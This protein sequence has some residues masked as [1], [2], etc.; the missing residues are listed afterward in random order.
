MVLAQRCG[1]TRVTASIAPR[2]GRSED[3][4]RQQVRAW[5]YDAQDKRGAKRQALD[6]S[7]CFAPLLRWVLPWWAPTERRRALAM[8]ASTL[9]QRCTVLSIRVL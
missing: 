1:R 7:T 3:A 8:D 5:W 6:G 9:G 2:V 4:V